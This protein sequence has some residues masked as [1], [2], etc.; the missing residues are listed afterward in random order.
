MRYIERS[1]LN[2]VTE[3]LLLAL[4]QGAQ[5]NRRHVCLLKVN[6][7]ARVRGESIVCLSSITR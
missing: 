7:T 4:L 6:I 1:A 5:G 3:R 2:A